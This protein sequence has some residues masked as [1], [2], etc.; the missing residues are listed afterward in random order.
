M[1]RD[2][3]NLMKLTKEEKEDEKRAFEGVYYAMV[4]TIGSIDQVNYIN[5]WLLNL[6]GYQEFSLLI[7]KFT[8]TGI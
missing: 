5:K 2:L 8:K 1:Q 7:R 6:G 3:D 4:A